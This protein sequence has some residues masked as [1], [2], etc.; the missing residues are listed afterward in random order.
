VY[1]GG[2]AVWCCCYCGCVDSFV[3]IVSDTLMLLVVSM[4]MLLLFVLSL[5]LFLLFSRVASAS[6]IFTNDAVDATTR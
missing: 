5:L 1:V 3:A 6:V 4:I 2:F